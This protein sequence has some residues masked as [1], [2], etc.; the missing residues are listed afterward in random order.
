MEIELLI[1]PDCPNEAPAARLLRQALD[2]VGLRTM[3]FTTVVVTS[4]ED[5]E[6]QQFTGSPTIRVDGTDP[7]AEPGQPPGMACRIYHTAMGP[8]GVPDLATLRQAL[9]QAAD[10]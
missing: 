10:H 8:A 1:V 4:P 2:D 6:K 7:F 3:R 5:A 9:K